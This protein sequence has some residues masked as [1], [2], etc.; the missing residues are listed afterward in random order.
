[1]AEVHSSPRKLIKAPSLPLFLGADPVL[2]E[3]GSWEQWEFQVRGSLDTHTQEAVCSVII[4]S[5]RGAMRELVGFIGYQ[6]ELEVILKAIE[7]RFGKKLTGDRLQQDFY[8]LTQER[9]EKIKT[10]ASRLEHIYRKLQ[11]RFPGKYDIKQMKDHL[12]LG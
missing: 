8:Q 3:E 6:S 1:M 10:F 5:V 12:F 4:K 11:D 2:K 9:G 7:K